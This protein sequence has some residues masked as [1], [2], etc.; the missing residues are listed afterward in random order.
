MFVFGEFLRRCNP[1]K[2]GW[3]PLMIMPTPYK[4]FEELKFGE[5]KQMWRL[6][7]K[8][9][10]SSDEV[11]SCGFS[12]R[13]RHFVQLVRESSLVRKDPIMLNVITKDPG[14]IR[15]IKGHFRKANVEVVHYVDGW[16]SDFVKNLGYMEA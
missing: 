1:Y 7:R 6:A 4:P 12:F 8:A 13:D 2:E 3:L 9:I 15:S 11:F 5:L 14:E 10:Q 16:L